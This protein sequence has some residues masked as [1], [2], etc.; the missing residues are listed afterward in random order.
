VSQPIDF[1]GHLV[2]PEHVAAREL[3]GELVLLNFDTER[4]FGLDDVGTRILEV[5]RDAASIEAGLPT[6]LEEFDVEEAQLRGD[7]SA[8]LSQLIDGGLVGLEPA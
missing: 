5:L 7:V 8:L 4:Y 2:V 6:L 3:D 1:S